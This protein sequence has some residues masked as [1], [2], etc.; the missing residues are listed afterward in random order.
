[1]KQVPTIILN[2]DELRSGIP[3]LTA[4]LGQVHAESAA[5]C[6]QNQG[7]SNLVPLHVPNVVE[8][9]FELSSPEV[10]DSM[11]RAYAD[12]QRATEL[13]A[14]GVGLLLAREITGLTAIQQSRKGTGFDYWLGPSTPNPNT[15]V[16]QNAAR[17]EVS[18][19]LSGTE[20]QFAS[21]VRQKLEQSKPSDSTGLP[22]FAVIV[23]FGRP[24]AQLSQR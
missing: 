12:L 24:Q 14:C 18:G 11:Q 15:L 3:A 19:L 8:K 21:R 9:R 23:E 20:K 17:L 1:M 13:G 22:A 2:L 5:V 16:F 10:T 4:A 7:H 6:L